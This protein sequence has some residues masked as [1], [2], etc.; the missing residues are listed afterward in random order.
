MVLRGRGEALDVDGVA[1][2]RKWAKE[3]LDKVAPMGK[4]LTWYETDDWMKDLDWETQEA[5]HILE[6]LVDCI[7]LNAVEE[8]FVDSLRNRSVIFKSK[9]KVTPKQLAWLQKIWDRQ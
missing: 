7:D 4:R 1:V 6:G 3:A 2:V 9:F 5:L 8:E